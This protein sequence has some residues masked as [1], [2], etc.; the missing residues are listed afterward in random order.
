[1]ESDGMES[2]LQNGRVTESLRLRQ[3]EMKALCKAEGRMFT[4]RG[5]S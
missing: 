5:K 4:H 3:V 1:M 2:L